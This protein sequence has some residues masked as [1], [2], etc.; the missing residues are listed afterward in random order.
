M[1]KKLHLVVRQVLT[2][3]RGV[4]VSFEEFSFS[5]GAKNGEGTETLKEVTC[6]KC[7]AGHA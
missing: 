7:K 4:L 2:L 1:V 6:P 3:E 5:C